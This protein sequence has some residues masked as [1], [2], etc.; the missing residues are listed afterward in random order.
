MKS[1]VVTLTKKQWEALLADQAVSRAEYETDT[2][3]FESC[4]PFYVARVIEEKE[5][6]RQP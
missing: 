1:F 2:D 6:V 5:G 3:V 4:L